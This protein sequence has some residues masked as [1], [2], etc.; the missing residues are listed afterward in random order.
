MA[1]QNCHRY[2]QCRLC[3]ILHC[4]CTKLRRQHYQSLTLHI[5][6][7]MFHTLPPH[8]LLHIIAELIQDGRLPMEKSLM[9]L[10]SAFSAPSLTVRPGKKLKG[11]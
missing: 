4:H 3:Q 8:P 10:Y 2:A 1:F 11:A 9:A 7:Q 5:L 6:M